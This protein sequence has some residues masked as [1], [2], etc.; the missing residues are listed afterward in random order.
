MSLQSTRS[1]HMIDTAFNHLTE[2]QSLVLARDDEH[3]LSGVHDCLDSHGEG[4]AGNGGEVV[5]EETTVVE[6]GFVC[7]GFDSGSGGE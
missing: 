6:D 5:V 1:N 7:E 3:D 4:H 2:R